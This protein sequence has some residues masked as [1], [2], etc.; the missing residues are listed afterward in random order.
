MTEKGIRNRPSVFVTGAD[1]YVGRLLVRALSRNRHAFGRLIASDIRETPRHLRLSGVDYR[2]AD[3]RSPDL[4]D[5][6]A[7]YGIDT[8]VHLATIV[9]PGK[10]SDREREFAVDVLGTENVIRACVAAGVGQLVVTSS[11]AAYGYHPD[12]PEWIDEDD[13]IRGNTEF[14]Y[15]FHKRL[16][17]EMLARY[18]TQAPGLRQLIF[19]PGTILGETTANQITALFEKPAVLGICG[20]AS[21]FVFIWDADVAASIVKGILEGKSGIFNLAGDG[22][23]SLREIARRLGKPYVPLPAWL[24]SGVLFLLT[25]AGVTRYGPEQVRFLRYRPVLSNR[26]LKTE[27]GYAPAKTSRETFEFW[28]AGR[29]HRKAA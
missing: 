19:R 2:V 28:L 27:F 22:C 10:D 29:Q 9:T 13:P 25:K 7:R 4:A 12:N 17:E 16:V 26:R 18:R 24:V 14:A 5:A 8:V 3:V 1:G 20:S 11:G 23:M 21:P 15:A 6:F